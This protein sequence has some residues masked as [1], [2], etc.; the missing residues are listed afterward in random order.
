MARPFALV[1]T[2]ASVVASIG[3][4]FAG[5]IAAPGCSSAPAPTSP[6]ATTPA[7]PTAAAPATASAPAAPGTP[8]TPP[9]ESSVL[10]ADILA[11][12]PVANTATV[13]HILI[14]WNDLNDAF[15]GHIDPR[16][17][18]RSKADA[19]AQVKALVEQLNG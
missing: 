14:S 9:A 2:L 1:S 7:S 19:E 4:S 16:A 10:S 3:I 12:E 5:A 18:K 8:A 17:A 15:Q 11:R 13:K 6:S